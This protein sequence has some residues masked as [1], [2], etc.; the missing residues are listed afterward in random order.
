ME[1]QQKNSAVGV[2]GLAGRSLCLENW[3]FALYIRLSA[4]GA[5]L[6]QVGCDKVALCV[7]VRVDPMID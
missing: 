2:I 7:D 5:G 3:A 6:R 1:V 4:D